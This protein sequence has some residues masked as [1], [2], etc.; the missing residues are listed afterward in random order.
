VWWLDLL[1]AYKE[2][3]PDADGVWGRR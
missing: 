1:W 3:A 2:P